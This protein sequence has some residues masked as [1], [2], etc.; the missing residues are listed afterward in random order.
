MMKLNYFLYMAEAEGFDDLVTTRE[1]RINAAIKDFIMMAKNGY[2]IDNDDIQA[3]ILED[4]KL[5]DISTKEAE[6]IARKVR[7]KL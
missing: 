7:S 2:N 5:Q 4:H 3:A 1:A 6:Y